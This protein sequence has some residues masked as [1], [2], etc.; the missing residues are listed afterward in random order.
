MKKLA[1]TIT[2]LTCALG[3]SQSAHAYIGVQQ[4]CREYTRTIYVGG[5]PQQG[6]GTACLQPDGSWQVVNEP[7]AIAPA[8]VVERVVVREPVYVPQPYYGYNSYYGSRGGLSI[9]I[10]DS[11]G[12]HRHRHH[13]WDRHDNGR[14]GRNGHHWR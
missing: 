5:R 6:Y 9:S 7:E 13:H 14:Y 11:W 4:Q 1:L 12:G 10:G 2:A 8:P 3:V